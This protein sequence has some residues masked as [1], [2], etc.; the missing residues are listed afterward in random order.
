MAYFSTK[1]LWTQYWLECSV[2]FKPHADPHCKYL[3]GYSLLLNL[4][5]VVST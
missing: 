4:H 2:S 5:L 3:H 1:N